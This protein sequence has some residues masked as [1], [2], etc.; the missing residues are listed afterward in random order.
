MNTNPNWP[1]WIFASL[2]KHFADAME[3]AK[4][5]LFIEG[6][7]RDTDELKEFVELRMQGPT[8]RQISKGCWWLRVEINILI[9]FTMN[10]KDYHRP[11]QMVGIVAAAFK[12]AIIAYK[13]GKGPDDDQTVLGCLQLLQ[14]SRSRE[15]LET[16]Q[17]GQIDKKTNI[18]QAA[19]EGH[20]KMILNTL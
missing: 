7:Y 9:Q 19:V 13:K 12:D 14:D 3:V 8:Y 15:F 5:P 17:F 20:Y 1:R 2:S 16:H 11:H 6:Q 18:I 10:D 4:I